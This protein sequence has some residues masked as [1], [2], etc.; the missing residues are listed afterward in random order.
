[1]ALHAPLTERSQ[2][3]IAPTLAGCPLRQDWSVAVLPRLT[4]RSTEPVAPLLGAVRMMAP[5]P[6]LTGTTLETDVDQ[7]VV[8]APLLS[9]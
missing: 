6:L 3:C 2:G 1:M 5:R 4:L 8:D 7:A 9:R